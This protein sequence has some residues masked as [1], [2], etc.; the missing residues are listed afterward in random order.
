MFNLTKFFGNKAKASFNHDELA[1]YLKITPEALNQF[2]QQYQKH[3]NDDTD[4]L[5]DD[6]AVIRKQNNPHFAEIK[7][8]Y[9]TDIINRIVD[10]L[11]ADTA[12][13]IIKDGRIDTT[14]PLPSHPVNPVTLEELE[15]I[16]KK[17]R[18]QLTGR[19]YC[20]DIDDQTSNILC[21]NYMMYE[22]ETDPK[23]K[24]MWYHLFRQG[25]DILDL[26][27]ITYEILG[28]NQ[29]S[30]GNWI[31]E[32][33]NAVSHTNLKIPDTTVIRVPLPLLQLSRK[34]Y[35]GLNPTTLRILDEY[36]MKI[37]EL[38]TDNDYFV[39]TGTYSSKFDFR[40]A[41]ITAGKEVTEL[42]EYLMFIQN[43]ACFAAGPL[44][45]PSIYGMSTTNEWCVREYIQ[46]A[47][48][49]PCIYKGMPLHTEYRVFI[50]FDTHEVLAVTPY[51]DK[52]VMKQRF[53]HEDDADSPHNKHDYIIYA[54]HE[55]TLYRRYNENIG[56]VTEQVRKLADTMRLTGQ[57]S[58]D[59][60]QNGDDFYAIDMAT[61]STSALNHVIPKNKL[62]AATEH[63]IPDLII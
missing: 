62:K 43:Q 56:Y 54:M 60:M 1:A 24:R 5:F 53:G 49:N 28:Q 39:K 34:E 37:F 63:W 47:E 15:Q 35:E 11:I 30:I 10:E 19:Y 61:A 45:Q 9:L 41:H 14:P 38:N 52:D 51:W 55:E 50:D 18:P 2:E 46:D 22:K 25:L 40:N 26:D 27:P 44:S 33:A 58:L 29:N 32:L 6:A 13:L 48:N 36:C 59:I 31:P 42:G 21:Y 57:W 4:N 23:K 7:D 12:R 3:I 17:Y 20:K 8:E 16:P